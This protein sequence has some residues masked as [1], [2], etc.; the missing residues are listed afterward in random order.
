MRL[1]TVAAPRHLEGRHRQFAACL[2]QTVG[3]AGVVAM[4]RVLLHDH[5]SK[6]RPATVADLQPARHAVAADVDGLV[7]QRLQDAARPDLD[8]AVINEVVIDLKYE[9]YIKRQLKQVEQFK[10]MESKMI[11]QSQLIFIY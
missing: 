9:G 2:S 11:N 4:E 1:A 5:V 3:N 6:L 8:R 10:K 7:W